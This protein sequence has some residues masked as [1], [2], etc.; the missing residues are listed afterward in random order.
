MI[1]RILGALASRV[2]D[3]ADSYG[4]GTVTEFH[5][6]AFYVGLVLNEAAM[7]LREEVNVS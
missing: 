5:L 7:R 2:W 3:V 1:A 4:D 6:V